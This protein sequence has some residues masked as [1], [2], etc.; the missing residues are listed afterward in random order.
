[1]SSDHWCIVDLRHPWPSRAVDLRVAWALPM[2]AA[3]LC[4]RSEVE[5]GPGSSGG[6]PVRWI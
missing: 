4:G 5:M 6:T 1:M 3:L 2:A